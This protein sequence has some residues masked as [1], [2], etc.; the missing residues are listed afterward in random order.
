MWYIKIRFIYP[1]W[2]VAHAGSSVSHDIDVRGVYRYGCACHSVPIP[3]H[4]IAVSEWVVA[5]RRTRGVYRY[6]CEP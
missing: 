5:V 6:A 3:V 2:L 4:H 1:D